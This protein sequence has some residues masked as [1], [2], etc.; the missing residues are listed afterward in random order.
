MPTRARSWSH[1]PSPQ[2]SRLE[3][4]AGFRNVLAHV[5][6]AI[7]PALVHANLERRDDVREYVAALQPVLRKHGISN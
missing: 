2:G 7:D 1:R 4:L 6:A 5:Y 3:S